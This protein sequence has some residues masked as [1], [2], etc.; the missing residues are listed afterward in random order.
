M[1]KHLLAAGAAILAG[2]FAIPCLADDTPAPA[3]NGQAARTT[4]STTCQNCHGVD[5]NS[6]SPTFP[7][8]NGQKAEYI[9]AQLKAFRGHTRADPHAQAY[10]W[11]MASQLDDALI[12]ELA[13]YYA[14]QVPTDPQAGGA[15][16][17]EGKKIFMEGAEKENIPPC[18]ACHGDH[19]EG[20]GTTP[21]LAGQHADYLVKQLEAFRSLSRQ[22]E[23]MHANTKDMT[24][25]QIVAIV[26]YLA[27][28]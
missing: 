10:M 9:E 23:V 1:T 14:G 18:P 24:D 3:G 2:L 21:R 12:A 25:S 26:S 22:N 6:T 13:K 5:G 7:R 15:L 11:G 8:L 28:D 27:N 16:A 20:N 17:A 4:I 19:G